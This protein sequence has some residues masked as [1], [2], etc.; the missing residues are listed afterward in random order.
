MRVG[1]YDISICDYGN[2][3]YIRTFSPFETQQ[4]I[5]NYYESGMTV[6]CHE[7]L[8][9]VNNLLNDPRFAD[10]PLFGVLVKIQDIILK[11]NNILKKEIFYRANILPIILNRDKLMIKEI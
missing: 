7:Y 10:K 3:E 2:A 11:H 5:L 1:E 8:L 4:Q 9:V 6:L